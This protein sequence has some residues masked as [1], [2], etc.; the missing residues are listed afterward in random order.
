MIRRPPRSTLFPYTTLF[1]SGI[2]QVG[3]R[4]RLAQIVCDDNFAIGTMRPPDSIDPFSRW[5]VT[6][7]GGNPKFEFEFRCRK[8]PRNRHVA[9]A[10]SDKCYDLALNRPALFLERKNV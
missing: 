8:H 2:E 6:L 10:V 4:G 9:P 7:R 3:A 1:R 5:L